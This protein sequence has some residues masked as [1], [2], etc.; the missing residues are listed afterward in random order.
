MLELVQGESGVHLVVP[1]IQ[2]LHQNGLLVLAGG[3]HVIRFMPSLYVTCKKIDQ[4]IGIPSK[5]LKEQDG[6]RGSI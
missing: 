1:I 5:V 3:T 4:A 6:R 2:K